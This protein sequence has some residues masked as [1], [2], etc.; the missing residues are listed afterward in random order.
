MKKTK[1]DVSLRLEV[2]GQRQE[3]L[4]KELVLLEEEE[5]LLLS[6]KELYKRE[7]SDIIDDERVIYLRDLSAPEKKPYTKTQRYKGSMLQKVYD[8]L[9]QSIH[10]WKIQEIIDYLNATPASVYCAVHKL[11][12]YDQIIRVSKGTYAANN[13][14][15]T[16]A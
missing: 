2:I 14:N 11:T 9:S 6:L 10:P 15:A 16:S 4:L 8:L 7:E 3:A 1:L 5:K 13:L 12:K